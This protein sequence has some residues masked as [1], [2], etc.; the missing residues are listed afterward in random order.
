[1][2]TSARSNVIPA[3]DLPEMTNRT[4]EAPDH[5]IPW[6][7][8][9]DID[10]WHQHVASQTEEE[11]KGSYASYSLLGHIGRTITVTNH[12]VDLILVIQHHGGVAHIS[13]YGEEGVTHYGGIIE[14]FHEVYT[15]IKS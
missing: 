14:G 1:M 7:A 8:C 6:W 4:E 9:C 12:E 15:A 10:R 2:G 13:A 5:G 3:S 11:A